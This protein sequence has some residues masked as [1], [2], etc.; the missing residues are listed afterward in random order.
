M[1][2]RS[3][4]RIRSHTIT[5]V[6]LRVLRVVAGAGLALVAFAACSLMTSFSGLSSGDPADASSPATDASDAPSVAV[7]GGADG[8]ADGAAP[9]Q[10]YCDTVSPKPDFCDD[11]E[12]SDVQGAWSPPGTSGG[13]AIELAASTRGSGRELHATIPVF[14][15]GG[16]SS[17]Q[18][19]RVFG[20]RSEIFASYA[21]RVDALPGTSS[22]QLMSVGVVVPASNGDFCSIYVF[23]RPQGIS[24]VEQT[25][26]GGA[27][28]GGAFAEH[29][30][31]AA[32]I[33]PGTWQRVDLL[34]KLSSPATLRLVV[35][36]VVAHEGTP[37]AFCR[38][39]TVTLSAGVHYSDA[40]SGPLSARVD[41]L[42]VVAK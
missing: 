26:P 5:D 8:R 13:G 2:P 11:F 15:G 17:A 27:G 29:S 21:L 25:F 32:P 20:D 10:P 31:A 22:Q 3:R 30:L 7:D 23:V 9:A 40:P 24:L 4:G 6:R 39:G 38:P 16:V 14:G 42:Y 34:L 1:K 19:E 36:G 37:N 41:D 18:V 35:D 28:A 12:R 33:V